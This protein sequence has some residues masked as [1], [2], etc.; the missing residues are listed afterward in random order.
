MNMYISYYIYTLLYKTSYNWCRIYNIILYMY[1]HSLFI[2]YCMQIHDSIGMLAI[3]PVSLLALPQRHPWRVV[4]DITIGC[5]WWI[6]QGMFNVLSEIRFHFFQG[7]L[8]VS[9]RPVWGL[10][11]ATWDW[12]WAWGD[13]QSTAGRSGE[14]LS[15]E[16]FE[17][18]RSSFDAFSEKTQIDQFLN[19]L[20]SILHLYWR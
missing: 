2:D 10:A 11:E 13:A 3:L 5:G 7:T 17:Q 9:R 6:F 14:A 1:R 20:K 4:G 15:W 12:T 8:I 16:P 19:R 18:W